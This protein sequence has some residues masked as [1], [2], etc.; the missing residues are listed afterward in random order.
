[1]R[2]LFLIFLIVWSLMGEPKISCASMSSLDS[3]L[4]DF[5]SRSFATS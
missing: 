2:D 1:M 5:T 3:L 4:I